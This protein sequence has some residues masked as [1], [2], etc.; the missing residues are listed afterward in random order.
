MNK[1]KQ[2]FVIGKNQKSADL[3]QAGVEM[4]KTAK[5]A[6]EPMTEALKSA[7]LFQSFNFRLPAL[8]GSPRIE[9]DS[10][11]IREKTKRDAEVAELR[12]LMLEEYREKRKKQISPDT[13]HIDNLKL[14]VPTIDGGFRY[15]E[16]ILRNLSIDQAEGRLL[17][18]F[19][20]ADTCFVEDEDALSVLE[21]DGNRDYGFVI[22]NLKNAFK[23]NG[24]MAI[25]ERR[26]RNLG[27]IFIDIE[28]LKKR[29]IRV[30][31]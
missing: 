1:K 31:T 21:L 23:N 12:R 27:Y 18:L 9:I 30:K 28:D 26:K 2:K 17:A 6:L 25:I 8:P 11:W 5:R 16:K 29:K 13:Q 22:R 7:S 19:L 10:G 20:Q 3:N 14:L 4:I 15:K 24:L